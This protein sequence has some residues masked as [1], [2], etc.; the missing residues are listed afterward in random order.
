MAPQ[1]MLRWGIALAVLGASLG[2]AGLG[3]AAVA[4][5]RSCGSDGSC[6]EWV[7]AI[8]SLVAL[9]VAIAVPV[10]LQA[11]A[12]RDARRRDAARARSAALRLLPLLRGL[13]ARAEAVERWDGLRDGPCPVFID[14]ADPDGERA[15]LEQLIAVPSKGW[16]DALLQ[17]AELGITGEPVHE[18][19]RLVL[20]VAEQVGRGVQT[21]RYREGDALVLQSLRAR[22]RESGLALDLAIRTLEALFPVGRGDESALVSG[23]DRVRARP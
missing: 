12:N 20:E 14:P 9:L 18:A 7:Q 11:Q 15:P 2:L 4:T 1:S 5:S 22:V 17:A 10:F 19:L 16:E 8:G 21:A 3:I 13:H 6:A 23:M